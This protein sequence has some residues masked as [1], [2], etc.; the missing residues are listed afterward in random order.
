M[1]D[2]SP[3]F[4]YGGLRSGT[5]L[6]RL[7]L[8]AHPGLNNPGEV[9]YLFDHIHH[10]DDDRWRYN[11]EALALDRSFGTSRLALPDLPADRGREILADFVRQLRSRGDGLM[12]LNV[13]RNLG[14]VAALFPGSRVIHVLRD[15]RDVASSCIGMGWAG[16]TYHG[17]DSWIRS[18][19]EWD[20]AAGA[21]AP[22]DQFELK[23]E[24][25]IADAPGRL[26]DVCAFLG[27]PFDPA[28]LRYHE[29]TTYG[30]PDP[31]MIDQ[32]RRK[33]ESHEL[34]I[35]EGK[36]GPLLTAHGYASSG[37]QPVSPGRGER[38]LLSLKNKTGVWQFSA[39]RYGTAVVVA[40]KASRWLG[41]KSWNRRLRTRINRMAEQHLK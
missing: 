24:A 29:R 6:F 15:P 23:Y 33:L 10:G 31:R 14:K 32:W 18:E 12:S 3:V 13:H 19:R 4:V 28:M 11:L 27:I 25:L 16:T 17:V 2:Q 37:V 41:L 5:T 7:M 21:I 1:S 38:I 8:N 39:R 9:D 26:H 34:A 20:R 30:P 22:D 35:L 36:L 40:E